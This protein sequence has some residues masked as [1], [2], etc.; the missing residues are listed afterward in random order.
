MASTPE[1]STADQEASGITNRRVSALTP[2]LLKSRPPG[3]A[4]GEDAGRRPS[5]MMLEA[6]MLAR[7]SKPSSPSSEPT[8]PNYPV[9][10]PII[11]LTP[12]SDESLATH[13][14]AAATGDS[15]QLQQDSCIIELAPS[16]SSSTQALGNKSSKVDQPVL[17]SISNKP[18]SSRTGSSLSIAAGKERR[19]CSGVPKF[20]QQL[21]M[22]MKISKD[23]EGKGTK[24]R[25]DFYATQSSEE[26]LYNV[27]S[28][29]TPLMEPE[30][31]L[32][33]QLPPEMVMRDG[34]WKVPQDPFPSPAST[35]KPLP[36]KA[37][38]IKADEVCHLPVAPATPPPPVIIF[39]FFKL[40]SFLAKKKQDQE[41]WDLFWEKIF[42]LVLFICILSCLVTT[43]VYLWN[44]LRQHVIGGQMHFYEEHMR[45]EFW[46][47]EDTVVLRGSIGKSLKHVKMDPLPC[48]PE[49]ELPGDSVCLEWKHKARL[50]M[51][52][53]QPAP[54]IHCYG[55]AWQ[56]L[57]A[58]PGPM[59][60]CFED[61]G[62]AWYGAG[63]GVPYPMN[64][65]NISFKP[66][67]SGVFGETVVRRFWLN[68]N[69][70]LIT[71]PQSVPLFVSVKRN[72]YQGFFCLRSQV[73]TKYYN[74]NQTLW[75]L[76]GRPMLSYTT[77]VANSLAQVHEFMQPSRPSNNKLPSSAG[78]VNKGKPK[79]N[80]KPNQ[81]LPTTTTPVPLVTRPLKQKNGFI[82]RPSPSSP[83][84]PEKMV[85]NQTH[86]LNMTMKLSQTGANH[87]WIILDHRWQSKIGD[88][89]FDKDLFPNVTEL[90]ETLRTRG[91]TIGL[92]ITPFISVNSKAFRKGLTNRLLV[93]DQSTPLP[94]LTQ[95]RD[96]QSAAVLDP[97][98]NFTQRWLLQKLENIAKEYN[99]T[100]FVLDAGKANMLPPSGDFAIN[101]PNPDMRIDY[102]VD[103]FKKAGV[104]LLAVTPAPENL[105]GQCVLHRETLNFSRPAQLK[106]LAHS[107]LNAVTLQVRCLMVI[108]EVVDRR[109]YNANLMQR[110]VQL[111]SILPRSSFWPWVPGEWN[112]A[113]EAYRNMSGTRLKTQLPAPMWTVSDDPVFHWVGDQLALGP[114]DFVAPVLGQQRNRDILLPSGIWVDSVKKEAFA[115]P[116]KLSKFRLDL[117]DMVY[118]SCISRDS[119]NIQVNMS[120]NNKRK[121][122]PE[123][124]PAD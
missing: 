1:L 16:S 122:K 76:Q 124:K 97:T 13:V 86:L 41:A 110:W 73:D 59:T 114:S 69:G 39:K 115:G 123:G 55:T 88:F 40:P 87:A 71:V 102:F 11:S 121:K 10:V 12:S 30:R 23:P 32:S 109:D 89:I 75:Q 64:S 38:L 93:Q 2:F 20:L 42:V 3:V 105:E 25:R 95:F 62:A 116:K 27:I 6:I 104:K 45:I 31:R 7:S 77:C 91:F 72:E 51:T 29:S 65:A 56:D 96:M 106:Q 21:S 108:V 82:Y 119:I 112:M 63:D 84:D 60:D 19:K 37:A 52:S 107:V 18:S 117:K 44:R 100:H 14:S 70:V 67:V 36:K 47:Q 101:L 53:S 35:P 58:R 113:L 118:F 15:S 33:T 66:F 17:A 78:M 57:R 99:I 81:S 103:V 50:H 94:A 9:E 22:E 68:S 83:K 48:L 24:K 54:G 28:L 80:K 98:T 74:V 49:G 61:S 4:A 90:M 92:E 120:N 43:H 111:V 8:T 5:A 85:F 79:A 26:E 46:N 34:E